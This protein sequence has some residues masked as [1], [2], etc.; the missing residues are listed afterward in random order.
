MGYGEF[1]GG[2]SV[3]WTVK[4]NG[5]KN[6]YDKDNDAPDSGVMTVTTPDGVKHVFPWSPGNK[7]TVR[8]AWTPDSAAPDGTAV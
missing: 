4:H 6:H 2:G 7:I 5:G 3:E 1:V 8:V